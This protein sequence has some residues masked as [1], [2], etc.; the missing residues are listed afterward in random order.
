MGVTVH[1][2]FGQGSGNRQCFNVMVLDDLV[3]EEEEN[4][5]LTMQSENVTILTLNASVLIQ[6]DDRK[7]YSL[8]INAKHVL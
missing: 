4:F 7:F 5:I 1:L 3:Y 2:T 6:D 8:C